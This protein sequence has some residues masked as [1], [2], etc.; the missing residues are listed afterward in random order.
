MPTPSKDKESILVVT[1][2]DSIQYLFDTL[3][4]ELFRRVEAPKHTA[5]KKGDSYGTL[6]VTYIK[7]SYLKWDRPPPK[8]KEFPEWLSVIYWTTTVRNNY[9]I[10]GYGLLVKTFFLRCRAPP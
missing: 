7:K 3:V 8:K 6:S 2:T 1:G 10:A 5:F 4:I 9:R